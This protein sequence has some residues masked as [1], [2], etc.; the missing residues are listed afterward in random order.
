MGFL[1]LRE[2]KKHQVK[3]LAL[4]DSARHIDEDSLHNLEI[5]VVPMGVAQKFFE[6]R[7]REESRKFIVGYLGKGISSGNDNRIDKIVTGAFFLKSHEEIEYSFV[8]L[9]KEYENSLRHLINQ[10]ELNPKK[11][12]F[13]DQVTHTDIPDTLRDF[14]VGVIPYPRS[15]YNDER[16]PL[17]ALEYAASGLPIIATDT[18]V[19]KQLFSEAFTNFFDENSA[20]EFSRAILNLY[21]SRDVYQLKASNARKFAE[22]FTYEMRAQK[23]I[24]L[25]KSYK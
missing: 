18:P 20:E 1:L 16:F 9:E 11:F 8:G 23:I 17:K 12:R 6:A 25:C 3:I 2:L 22:N 4:T 7:K 14:S 24:D 19:H 13:I 21:E 10:L 15:K 5:Y